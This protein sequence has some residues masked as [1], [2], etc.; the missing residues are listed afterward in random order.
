MRGT[1]SPTRVCSSRFGWRASCRPTT[2]YGLVVNVQA[3]TAGGTAERE[4][5]AQILAD[6][7][8]RGKGV[9]VGADKS[10]D[11]KGVVKACRTIKVT[12]HV[13]QNTKRNGG[14]VIDAP[15]TGRYPRAMRGCCGRAAPVRHSQERSLS[16][17]I[18][19]MVERR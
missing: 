13:A 11:T 6:A 12:P 9:T 16:C 14:S 5:A 18:V 7:T 3:R 15:R 1:D 10:Y 4:V 2:R 8:G 19:K 17:Q